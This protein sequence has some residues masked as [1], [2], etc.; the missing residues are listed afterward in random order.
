MVRNFDDGAAINV[1]SRHAGCETV[2]VDVGVDL[3]LE[4]LSKQDLILD[5]KIEK[6]PITF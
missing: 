6:G 3:G 5:R 1:L 2:I 4:E